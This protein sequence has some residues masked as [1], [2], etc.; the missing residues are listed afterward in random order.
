MLAVK[1]AKASVGAALMLAPPSTCATVRLRLPRFGV[2]GRTAIIASAYYVNYRQNWP[3][4]VVAPTVLLD[5]WAD[6]IT[7]WLLNPS[8]DDIRVVRKAILLGFCQLSGLTGVFTMFDG[9]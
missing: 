8:P 3:V 7:R 4:L 6:E 5:Q 9:E 1:S 2:Q